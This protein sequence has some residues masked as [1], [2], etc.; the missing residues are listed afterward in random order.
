MTDLIDTINRLAAEHAI[1]EYFNLGPRDFLP[2]LETV[3]QYQRE[4][5]VALMGKSIIAK[6]WSGMP[7]K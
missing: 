2:S 5:I 1:R 6:W 4:E 3:P 7:N